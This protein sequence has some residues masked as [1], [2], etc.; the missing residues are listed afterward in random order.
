MIRFKLN[1]DDNSM[2]LKFC[3]VTTKGI[4]KQGDR[5]CMNFISTSQKTSFEILLVVTISTILIRHIYTFSMLNSGPISYKL[6]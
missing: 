4:T 6:S 3:S 5:L 1:C 2:T